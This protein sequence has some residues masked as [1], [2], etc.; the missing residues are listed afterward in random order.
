MIN[1]RR[2]V[3]DD[4]ESIAKLH[5]ASWRET[6]TGLL[7]DQLIA[8]KTVAERAA[9]WRRIL[10]TDCTSSEP[11]H[12]VFL[13]T[14]EGALLGFGSYGRQRDH[15]ITARGFTGEFSAIYILRRA[16]RRGIGRKLMTLMAAK[17]LH[18]GFHSASLLVLRDNRAACEFYE[19]I[20]GAALSERNEERGDLTLT[21]VIYGWSDL[22]Q[23]ASPKSPEEKP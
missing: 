2:A 10:L 22:R 9:A 6:Y 21:E 7:P 5:L 11:H 16:Q 15:E 14:Q 20:G 13:A 17:L 3:L 4:A 8:S 1:Y 18:E 12:R 19:H 23:L